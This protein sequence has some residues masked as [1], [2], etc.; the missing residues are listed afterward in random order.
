MLGEDIPNAD[1]ALHI[2]WESDIVINYA[3]MGPTVKC[4]FSFML[5]GTIYPWY[6]HWNRDIQIQPKPKYFEIF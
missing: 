1:M 6:Q 5:P 4:I 2:F 3:F